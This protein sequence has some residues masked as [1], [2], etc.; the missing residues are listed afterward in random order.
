MQHEKDS[1][2]SQKQLWL[3]Y[4]DI[5]RIKRLK[6]EVNLRKY[7][8]NYKLQYNQRKC[9]DTTDQDLAQMLFP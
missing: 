8:A 7:E 5:E 6:D 4:Q 3:E 1:F 2:N 9:P